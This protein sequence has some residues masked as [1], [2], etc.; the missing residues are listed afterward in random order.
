MDHRL[1]PLLSRSCYRDI[2]EVLKDKDWKL[3]QRKDLSIE[4][5]NKLNMTSGPFLIQPEENELEDDK[6]AIICEIKNDELCFT[7]TSHL[8][9]MNLIVK[10]PKK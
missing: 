9:I 7:Q 6:R 3:P 4:S 8:F 10:A 1:K 2:S 5:L